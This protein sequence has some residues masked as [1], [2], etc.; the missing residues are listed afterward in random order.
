MI[1]IYITAYGYTIASAQIAIVY[2]WQVGQTRTDVGFYIDD[3]DSS[4]DSS[5]VSLFVFEMQL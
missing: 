1:T 3:G 4:V 2:T 5:V